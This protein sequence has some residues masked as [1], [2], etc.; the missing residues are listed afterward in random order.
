M[1]LI[2]TTFV[3]GSQSLPRLC[4]KIFYASIC[5]HF[6]VNIPY[7]HI[8][9]N[10][11]PQTLQYFYHFYPK[12]FLIPGIFCLLNCVRSA[13]LWFKTSVGRIFP[14]CVRNVLRHKHIA[15]NS[16]ERVPINCGWVQRGAHVLM[17]PFLRRFRKKQR[18]VIWLWADLKENVESK[19]MRINN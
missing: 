11:Y 16:G 19:A 12:I 6:L 4:F 7:S 15:T 8:Y 10:F 5:Q 14:S 9:S 17:M 3:S 2:T 13:N 18:S 1:R